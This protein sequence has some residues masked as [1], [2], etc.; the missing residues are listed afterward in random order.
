MMLSAHFSLEELVTTQQRGLDN[1][2]DAKVIEN[3]RRLASGQLEEVR[4]LLGPV[5]VTSGYRSPEVNRAVGGQATSQHCEGLAAD[6]IVPRFSL[7]EA[8]RRILQQKVAFDQ[9]IFEFGR[10]LHL[11][12]PPVG[13]LGRGEALMIGAWTGGRYEVLDLAK[14]PRAV[15]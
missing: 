15:A 5:H 6:F 8:A 4:M 2:P 12:I 13:R 9:F 3:L 1:T 10:W 14:L 11:S 7:Q